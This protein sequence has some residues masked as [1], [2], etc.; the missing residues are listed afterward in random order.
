MSSP[1]LRFRRRPRPVPGR[2]CELCAEPAGPGHGH[3]IDLESR[4]IKCACRGCALLFTRPGAGGGRFRTVPGRYRHL[5]SFPAGERL[6]EAVAIPV[7]MA[8]FFTN[9]RLGRTTAFYPGPA[10]AAESLL[11][12]E[13]GDHLLAGATAVLGSPEPDVEAV[14]VN[15]AG[16]GFEAF[17][18][19]ID[20][21]YELVGLAKLHW[22]GFDGGAEAWQAIDGFFDKL[23]QRSRSG[24]AD[25]G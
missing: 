13:E 4:T 19:P 25:D 18:V 21:C 23:R 7:R 15:R 17:L 14:L 8:F 16:E 3:V 6:W 24:E 22:R 9:S 20:A 10:G 2:Q 1:L 5:P 11:P 12:I